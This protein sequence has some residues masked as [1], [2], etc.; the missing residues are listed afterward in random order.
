[1]GYARLDLV[2]SARG[3]VLSDRVLAIIVGRGGSKG[4]PGKNVALL[5]G[6]P[7]VAWS[8]AAAKGARS[9]TRAILS[10][11]DD[12][13]IAAAQAAG[14]EVPF[15]RPPEL[16]TDE[17]SV[18]DAMFHAV[19][20]L[21]EEYETVVLLQ[22]TSPLRTA[23]DIDEAVAKLRERG[24]PSVVSVS[25]APK[26]PHWMYTLDED[27]L[28]QVVEEAWSSDRRQ[29][30]PHYYVPNGAVYVA[31]LD[32]LR[33]AGTFYSPETIG[34]VMPRE[35]S[36]DIDA[37]IDLMVARAIIETGIDSRELE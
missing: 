25:L 9:V 19:D 8:V 22:A 21:D 26:P 5:A 6:K 11:D 34:Y 27:R 23:D 37:P 15:K 12:D 4:L 24:A 36:I 29:A 10:S 35:R 18:Y 30:L 1:M 20:Q 28:Q 31:K 14:C 32:W 16:A 7:L 13:I 2:P 17:A 33:Q 3:Q